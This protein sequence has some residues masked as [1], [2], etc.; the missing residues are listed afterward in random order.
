MSGQDAITPWHVDFSYTSVAYFPI[1]GSKEFFVVPATKLSQKLF[2]DFTKH[3]NADG[4][5]ISLVIFFKLFFN[6]K[7]S[8]SVYSRNFFG[9]HRKLKEKVKRI[10]VRRDQ[11]LIMPGGMPHCVRTTETTIACGINFVHIKML[12]KFSANKLI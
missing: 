11:C 3:G 2:E 10:T 5:V 12:S 8:C 1:V 4:L 7:D 6:L 9:F